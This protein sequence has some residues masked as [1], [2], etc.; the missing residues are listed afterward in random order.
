MEAHWISS[1]INVLYLSREEIIELPENKAEKIRKAVQATFLDTSD[2]QW[3]W[4][5]LIGDEWSEEIEDAW[6]HLSSVC[7]EEKVW[8][9]PLEE[10]GS[11]VYETTPD[12]VSK[13]LGE[14]PAFE[15]A[16]VGQNL[17]WIL[18]ENHHNY[19]IGCGHAVQNKLTAKF[20]S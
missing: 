3:W 19:L 18:I 8:F 7:P 20:G 13:V 15:Y 16:L 1:A 2:P 11:A 6:K 9:I 12:I 10:H 14:S 17:D 5:H 4:E